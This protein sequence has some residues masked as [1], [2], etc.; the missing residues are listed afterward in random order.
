MSDSSGTQPAGEAIDA[1]TLRVDRAAQKLARRARLALLVV[2]LGAVTAIGIAHQL[3]AKVVGV[4]ALCP[5]G[6]VETFWSL[7]AGGTLVQRVAASSVILL[8]G[9]LVTALLFRRA[10]CGYICPL[11]AIQELSAKLGNLIFRG[12]RPEMPAWLDRPA[13]YLK[14]VVF[15]GFTVWSWQAASLVM[16]PYDPWVAWMHLTSKEV[17]AEFSIGLVVLGVTVAGS[18]IYDRFFCK[19][20]CPMGAL[21]GAI[22][23]VSLFKVR[24]NES[25]CTSCRAC[26]KVCPVNVKVSTMDVVQDP[27]CI[28]CNECINVCPAKGTLSVSAPGSIERRASLKPLITMGAVLGLL[29]AVVVATSLTGTFAWTPSSLANTTEKSSATVNVDD[30]RGSMSFA[31]VSK[32]TGIPASEFEKRFGIAESDMNTPMKDLAE[33]HGFDVHTDVREFVTEHA[34]GSANK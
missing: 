26:D 17:L 2:V 27:E 29:L 23:K 22:S 31:E 15:A 16:R 21:L 11:G 19:Y 34:G 12:K 18:V 1:G 25:T 6:G 33:A 28:N 10:F 24:R 20:A 13:R 8:V 30:I 5:F 7:I 4:D 3:G 9:I 32:A 14:Y